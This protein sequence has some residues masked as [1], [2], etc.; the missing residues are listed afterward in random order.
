M[1]LVVESPRETDVI[2]DAPFHW[3]VFPT[4]TAHDQAPASTSNFTAGVNRDVVHYESPPNFYR[5][6]Q[7]AELL[8]SVLSAGNRCNVI[9]AHNMFYFCE[10]CVKKHITLL[11]E[12]TAVWPTRNSFWFFG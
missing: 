6:G 4:L 11:A 1:T 5:N 2:V 9:I 3:N 8:Q 12:T 7:L 10:K